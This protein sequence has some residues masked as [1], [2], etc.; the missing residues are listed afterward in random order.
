MTTQES[1]TAYKRRTVHYKRAI[2]GGSKQTLQKIL[3]DAIGKGGEFEL[4]VNRKEQ[5]DPK[6]PTGGFHLIN[7]SQHFESILFGQFLLF[8]PGKTQAMLTMDEQAQSYKID[9]ITTASIKRK[10]VIKEEIRSLLNLSFILVFL[11]IMF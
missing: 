7:K 2:I 6:D 11:K 8:E 1:S 9:P 3:E 5:I 4:A 10:E